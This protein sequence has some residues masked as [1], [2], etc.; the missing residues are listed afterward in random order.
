M[1][2]IV[3]ENYNWFKENLKELIKDYDNKY[4]VIK[5]KKILSCMPFT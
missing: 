3:N 5:N 2:Q 1:D 4:I